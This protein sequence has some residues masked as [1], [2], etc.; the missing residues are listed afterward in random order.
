MKPV[1]KNE[2]VEAARRT[3]IDLDLLDSNLAHTHEQRWLEHEAALE[4]VRA[5]EKRLGI[6][7][8]ESAVIRRTRSG[9]ELLFKVHDG[10][11]V[12]CIA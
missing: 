5:Y 9:V 2:A 3:G 6:K 8:P 7:I 12:Q 4:K 1:E 10:Y 11:H